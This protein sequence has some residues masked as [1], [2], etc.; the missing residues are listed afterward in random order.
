MGDTSR[1]LV[2]LVGAGGPP[3]EYAL[4]RLAAHADVYALVATQTSALQ[5][6]ILR[7]W[8]AD[9]TMLDL[10]GRSDNIVRDIVRH[11]RHIAA[12]GVITLSEFGVIAVAEAC[13]EL[14]LPGPGPNARFARDKWLM[15][16]RWSEADLPVPRF[17]KVT[18]LADLEAAAKRLRMPFLLKSSGRGGG[19]GQQV[20]SEG[21][22]L[23]QVMENVSLAL[24]QAA[25]HGIV[26]YSEQLDVG[27]CVA[28]EIIESTIES[29]YSDP[30]YGDFLSVEGIVAAGVYHPICVTGRFPTLPPFA[31]I[32]AVSP[33]V[34]GP[35]SQ[36]RIEEMAVRA[37]NA[38]GLG[39][40][41]THT[42]IKLMADGR[43][44]MLETA[45]RVGGSTATALAEHVFGADL[46][47]MQAREVLGLPV[48]YPD[49]MLIGGEGAAASIFL[50]AADSAG[51]PWKSPMEFSWRAVEWSDLV[52]AASRVEIMPSQMVPDGSVIFPYHPGSGA[53][54]YAGGALVY[55]PDPQT[56]LNDSYRL[57]DNLESA[58]PAA[59]PRDGQE[60]H[61]EGR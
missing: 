58:L 11:A 16:Q 50:F 54:N 37:V 23:P 7:Q 4:P 10:D 41:G 35:G 6:S 55:S 36:R 32:G 8:C 20:I 44:C 26:E 47:G 28:E 52:S 39:T 31:E 48:S 24:A 61:A 30:R 49:R 59:E 2:W 53:L 42:E 34:I 9:V 46:I 43:M 3:F 13:L 5:N 29:W 12:D 27:H 15:R 33:C 22:S 14:G 56:L 17:A 57:I 38:L 51:Q 18:N 1:K 60:R 19:I 45:A 25:D 21:T 40:C